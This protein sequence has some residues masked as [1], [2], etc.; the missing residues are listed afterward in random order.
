MR[1]SAGGLKDVIRLQ[2]RF[3]VTDTSRTLS[4]EGSVM[5]PSLADLYAAPKCAIP[6]RSTIQK[7]FRSRVFLRS[8]REE[9]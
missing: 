2:M 3:S 1:R 7:A 4:A 9:T 6:D 8:V 5:V